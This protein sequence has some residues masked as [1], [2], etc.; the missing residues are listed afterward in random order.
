MIDGHFMVQAMESRRAIKILENH[1]R[2]ETDGPLRIPILVLVPFVVELALK[3]LIVHSRSGQPKPKHDLLGLYDQLN[4]DVKKELSRG[5][6]NE[7]KTKGPN[8]TDYINLR[9]LLEK[10]KHSYTDWRYLKD[11]ASMSGEL[12]MAMEVAYALANEYE[13]KFLQEAFREG[14]IKVI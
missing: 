1:E 11:G 2:Q 12:S 13:T 10:H 5:F 14:D 6:A 7:Q 4:D 9:T 8:E 3:S